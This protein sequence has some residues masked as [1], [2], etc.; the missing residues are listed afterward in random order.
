MCTIGVCGYGLLLVSRRSRERVC[1]RVLTVTHVAFAL[2]MVVITPIPCRINSKNAQQKSKRTE[3]VVA[4]WLQPNTNML[5]MLSSMCAKIH[6]KIDNN[7]H[8]WALPLRLLC[9]RLA[10]TLM[11]LLL[12]V[13]TNVCLLHMRIFASASANGADI[14]LF[15]SIPNRLHSMHSAFL[16]DLSRCWFSP[17]DWLRFVLTG[18]PPCGSTSNV[19][20][21]CARAYEWLCMRC[22]I[23]EWHERMQR[24]RRSAAHNKIKTI[25]RV[26]FLSAYISSPSHAKWKWHIVVKHIQQ[27]IKF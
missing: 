22:I 27:I 26:P 7:N 6:V 12:A 19:Y 9:P 25:L 23:C 24:I 14:A 21:S 10:G 20:R 4:R 17:Y 13:C 16:C 15:F 18:M 1:T 11:L 5:Q 2:D 3:T 8:N